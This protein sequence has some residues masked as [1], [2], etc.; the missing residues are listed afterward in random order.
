MTARKIRSAPR[1]RTAAL[2]CS[3]VLLVCSLARADQPQTIAWRTDYAKARAESRERNLPLWVQFT[4]PWCPHCQR[5]DREVLV[6]Q[7]IVTLAREQFIPLKLRSDYN[8]ALTARFGVSGLPATCIVSPE[9]KI[10]GHIEGFTESPSFRSFLER[11]IARAGSQRRPE[12]QV[13]STEKPAERKE[14]SLA[15]AEPEAAGQPHED[16]IP[17]SK[18]HKEIALRGDAHERPSL[19][20]PGHEE[21]SI[22]GE[23]HDEPAL[24]ALHEG[25]HQIVPLAVKGFCP[26]TLVVEHKLVPGKEDYTAQHEGRLY[27]FATAE[28]RGRFLKEPEAFVPVNDG[29]CPVSQVDSGNAVP[30]DPHFGA[31]YA[32]HLFLCASDASRKRFLARPPRYELAEAANKG[33]CPHCRQA[34][35]HLVRGSSRYSMIHEGQRYLF[36]DQT[37]LEAFRTDPDRYL[38]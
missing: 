21:P 14:K 6:S 22:R 37:H 29:R 7:R 34:E 18:P 36:P 23:A 20:G 17:Q 8:E 3:I 26:V 1:A 19:R 35:G 25:I 10:V 12:S 38:R 15:H 28:A 4:G 16:S 32:G 31:L 9:G 30:G 11:S 27:R 13:A 33:F 24:V 5:M 2:G